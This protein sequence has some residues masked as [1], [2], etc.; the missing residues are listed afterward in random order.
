MQAQH[1]AF[2]QLP[3]KVDQVTED[4]DEVQSSLKDQMKSLDDDIGK[5]IKEM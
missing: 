1:S 3:M 5:R 4:F 2:I